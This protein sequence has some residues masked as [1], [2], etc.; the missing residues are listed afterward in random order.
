[1]KQKFT[2]IELLVV[3]S[4][5]AILAGMLLPALNSARQKAKTLKCTNTLKTMGLMFNQ[6]AGDAA[7]HLPAAD[8]GNSYFWYYWL[9]PYYGLPIPDDPA[10]CGSYL[11]EKKVICQTAANYF[12][13]YKDSAKRYFNYAMSQMDDKTKF[14][15]LA[16]LKNPSALCCAGDAAFSITYKWFNAALNPSSNRPSTIHPL[17]TTNILF[18]DSHVK[19][20]KSAE[21]PTDSNDKFWK[22]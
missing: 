13:Q 20:L 12:S 19:N 18:V 14:R 3:I 10:G 22:P 17:L 6:Y 16:A 15:K 8:A 5:I 7:G 9:I 4:I 21:I 11:V 1:M 2:L